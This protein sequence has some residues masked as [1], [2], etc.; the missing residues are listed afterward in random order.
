MEYVDRAI[1][2]LAEKVRPFEPDLTL[3]ILDGGLYP[4]RRI[5]K[6]LKT[7]LDYMR[8]SHYRTQ[9]SVLNEIPGSHF[10]THTLGKF[11]TPIVEQENSSDLYGKKV[12]IVDDN[13]LTLS[14]LDTS[15]THIAK[16]KPRDIKTAV[17]LST[18]KH[19]PDYFALSYRGPRHLPWRDSS[20]YYKEYLEKL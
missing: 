7:D 2:L 12:L 18:G 13:S 11:I 15:K 1:E 14:T 10:I 6:I 8:I 19:H 17:V 3:G 4:A 20:P 16:K 9:L 5:S